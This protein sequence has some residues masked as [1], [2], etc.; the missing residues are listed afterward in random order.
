MEQL[1][2]R[3]LKLIHCLKQ[4]VPGSVSDKLGTST[5]PEFFC[6]RSVLV[7]GGSG[8][9]GKVLLSKLLRSCPDIK[10]IY[11]LIRSS[12]GKSASARLKE[13]L[14][15]PVSQ[16]NKILLVHLDLTFTND[17]MVVM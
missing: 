2:L 11:V 17:N 15:F 5:I 12:R 14:A 10:H 3:I 4:M 9:M 7:T 6:G 1:Y 13:I 16:I 8:F